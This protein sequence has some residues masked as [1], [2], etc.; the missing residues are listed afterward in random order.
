MTVQKTEA[1]DTQIYIK[2]R[3]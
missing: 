3:H 2:A 1:R